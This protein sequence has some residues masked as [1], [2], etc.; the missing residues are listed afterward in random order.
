MDRRRALDG[1][2]DPAIDV[3]PARWWHWRPMAAKRPSK[4]A[5]PT[6]A[7]GSEA[8]SAE[9]VREAV[10]AFD[11][12]DVAVFDALFYNV[13]HIDLA[14][15][16]ELRMA[17][18]VEAG[19]DVRAMLKAE[20]I[21][22]S[23]LLEQGAAVSYD[24]AG[25][26]DRALEARLEALAHCPRYDGWLSALLLSRTAS[27][28]LA[29]GRAEEALPLAERALRFQPLDPPAMVILSRVREA[30]GDRAEAASLRAWLFDH[31]VS[32]AILPGEPTDADRLAK[33]HEPE[34]RG[35]EPMSDEDMG[36]YLV[37]FRTDAGLAGT[38]AAGRRHFSAQLRHGDLAAAEVA[39]GFYRGGSPTWADGATWLGLPI[40]MNNEYVATTA[41]IEAI[42]KEAKARK[43]AIKP[44]DLVH[45][46]AG[47]RVKAIGELAAASRPVPRHLL[48]DLIWDVAHAA[49]KAL[50]NDPVV[51]AAARAENAPH[52]AIAPRVFSDGPE[53][54][55]LVP[56]T[57]G[58]RDYFVRDGERIVYPL[59]N[60]RTLAL[61]AKADDWFPF[62]E[63]A[64]NARAKCKVC[65]S[66]IDNGA[67]RLVV[68]AKLFPVETA[69]VHVACATHKKW[70]PLYKKAAARSR[71]AL[72]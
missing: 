10:A 12:N 72:P 47:V 60:A 16:L 23:M 63:A 18:T 30:A 54:S 29:L 37:L 64:T 55:P 65:K 51:L 42:E 27:S 15:F 36:R 45:R 69:Y 22:S 3:I 70:A 13:A 41:L 32:P 66:A 44:A 4:T 52:M 7:A 11:G 58:Q 25:A 38:L 8:P 43:L 35:L 62:I 17:G 9:R 20:D 2:R 56:H 48:T 40:T 61:D 34:L 68:R 67:L 53:W 50:P 19:D 24:A 31:G 6:P 46:L 5:S 14:R 39:C 1:A 33:P 57:V 71:L 26:H 59:Q 21:T 49:R 28:L